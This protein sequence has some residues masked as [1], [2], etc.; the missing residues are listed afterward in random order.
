MVASYNVMY[1]TNMITVRKVRKVP[2]LVGLVASI[3]KDLA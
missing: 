1:L 2:S 3:N